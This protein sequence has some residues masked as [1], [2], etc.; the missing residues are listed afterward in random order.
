[1]ISPSVKGM[2]HLFPSSSWSDIWKALVVIGS[3][4]YFLPLVF[5]SNYIP[6]LLLKYSKMLIENWF[7]I[8]HLYLARHLRVMWAEFCCSVYMV[9]EHWCGWAARW[10]EE[11]YCMWSH[12]FHAG[13]QYSRQMYQWLNSDSMIYHTLQL[14]AIVKIEQWM[15]W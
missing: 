8:H 1:M 12:F 11:F 4:A 9:W 14:Y 13:H 6:I 7:F 5:C 3:D 10:W 15:A 2:W